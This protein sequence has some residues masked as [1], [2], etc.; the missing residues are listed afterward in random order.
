MKDPW[1]KLSF[2]FK[3][4][5]IALLCVAVSPHFSN[6]QTLWGTS[7][8]GGSNG[9]GV[10]Y[11]T[12][13][14]G[15]G[16]QVVK[17][18]QIDYA[19]SAA[20]NEFITGPGEFQNKLFALTTGGGTFEKGTIYRYDPATNEYVTLYNFE[21]G[22]NGESPSGSLVLFNNKF[23][24]T[25]NIPMQGI[26]TFGSGI[27]FEFDPATNVFKKMAYLDGANTGKDLHG[28]LTAYNNKLYGMTTSGGANNLGTIFEFDPAAAAESM[29]VKKFD[30]TE[31]SGSAPY[32]KLTVVNDK[33]YGLT[34]A[35]GLSWNYGTLFEFDPLAAVGS[36]YTVKAKFDFTTGFNPYGSLTLAEGKLYG[37]TT[38]GGL[39]SD[40]VLFEYIP[41]ESQVT[42]LIDINTPGYLGGFTGVSRDLVYYN[43]KLFG[44]FNAT[45]GNGDGI[46]FF[47]Y[48][49]TNADFVVAGTFTTPG[50]GSTSLFTGL[51]LF[52]D[53][54]Y[55]N[56]QLGRNL[57]FEYD[58]AQAM[59]ATNPARKVNLGYS[60]FPYRPQ[61]NSLT[62]A[63]GR[64]FGSLYYG[65]A[66]NEGGLYTV[67]TSTGEIKI[68]TNDDGTPVSRALAT[69][70]IASDGKL[71]SAVPGDATAGGGMGL[72]DSTTNKLKVTVPLN[73][74]IGRVSGKMVEAANKKLYGIT[75]GDGAF[76]YG[77]L[78]EL[79]P[80]DGTYTVKFNFKYQQT[81]INIPF[82]LTLAPNGKLYGVADREGE[83]GWGVI[84]EYVPGE[85]NI[86]VKFNFSGHQPRGE[87]VYSSATN[88]MYGISSGVSVLLPSYIYEYTLPTAQNPAGVFA[89]VKE[90]RLADG[91]EPFGT[92]TESGNGKL[93]GHAR[94]GWPERNVIFEFNAIAS[95]LALIHKFNGFDGHDVSGYL[96]SEKL[97]QEIRFDAPPPL[98]LDQTPVT[99][100]AS[101]TSN[102]PLTFS[103]SDPLIATVVGNTLRFSK[104]GTVTVT[105]SQPGNGGYFPATASQTITVSKGNQT[106]NVNPAITRKINDGPFTLA[107]SSTSALPLTFES[108]NTSVATVNGSEVTI[109]GLG[110]TTITIKQAGNDNYYAAADA[111]TTLTV[112]KANQAIAFAPLTN[113]TMKDESFSLVASASS[114]LP[115][116]FTSSNPAIASIT[117]SQVQIHSRGTI[118]VTALQAGNE[119]YDAGQAVQ[120]LTIENLSPVA[121]GELVVPGATRGTPYVLTISPNVFSD[122]ENDILTLSIGPGSTTPLPS[123]ILFDASSRTLSGTP[124]GVEDFV[125]VKVIAT[126]TYQA[127]AS[128]DIKIPIVT[129]T[130]L[131]AEDN[132]LTVFPNPVSDELTVKIEG[133]PYAKLKIVS[134]L[135]NV[136]TEMGQAMGE[137][138]I[139]TSSWPSGLY[140]LILETDDGY[141]VVKKIVH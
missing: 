91:L 82:G 32:G 68:V 112:T 31:S 104:P 45:S 90:L 134:S 8:I 51:T 54:L 84:F 126:D 78:F 79:D 42:K 89:T 117:G 133:M 63:F 124:S 9:G 118:S 2:T 108:S 85:E 138:R 109:T 13:H 5:T 35:G 111:T 113:K 95:S 33:M 136:M 21:G 105:A 29:L 12:N 86:T 93:Y 94:T 30:L 22:Q 73:S 28:N 52:G 25:A 70:M 53:K 137:L 50:V 100:A 122:P 88:K 101:T 96:T 132:K 44:T 3:I 71:F 43:G 106:I 58:P 7:R 34:S 135:G 125:I 59:S 18:F 69:A 10:L 141:R 14:D 120:T 92:L 131:E 39:N 36:N 16:F 130:G 60:A 24:G 119:V 37:M 115:V 83:F 74:G 56:A 38:Q 123:W 110:T 57:I 140:V 17:D 46:S 129:V 76:G 121:T 11:K 6:G 49:I 77:T 97:E 55:G 62:V 66:N 4:H 26:P 19:G 87:L 103:V 98:R 1:M 107:A 65:G 64:L 20:S 40:G 48:D 61:A 99:L 47:S 128:V 67:D 127:S 102:L 41:G 114:G 27:I 72:F 80:E 23:Y 75:R 15:S 139:S 81:I 116:Q